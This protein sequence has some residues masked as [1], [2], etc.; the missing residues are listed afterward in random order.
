MPRACGLLAVLLAAGSALARP[1]VVIVAVDKPLHQVAA[2]W[3][4]RYLDA[5]LPLDDVVVATTADDLEGLAG[6]PGLPE[7]GSA[8]TLT[9]VLAGTTQSRGA[10]AELL[11]AGEGVPLDPLL[12]LFTASQARAVT[13]L[14][15][16]VPAARQQPLDV[17]SLPAL[18]NPPRPTS[19][20]ASRHERF[21]AT[22]TL[23]LERLLADA[24]ADG[25]VDAG[26]LGEFIRGQL[27]REQVVVSG[28]PLRALATPLFGTASPDRLEPLLLVTEPRLSDDAPVLLDAV[29][30]LTVR[31]I[32]ADDR[33]LNGV[34]VNGIPATLR[35]ATD[36]ALDGL[37]Y[38]GRTMLFEAT[39]PVAERGFTDVD[40]TAVDLA[41]NRGEA[42]F[43][44]L[45]TGTAASREAP[46][47]ALDSI[48][49]V[50]FEWGVT[51]DWRF[52]FRADLSATVHGFKGR[53][54]QAAVQFRF[55][56]GAWLKDLN[57][58]YGDAAGLVTATTDF[59]PQYDHAVVKGLRIFVPQRELHLSP[60]KK[61]PIEAVVRLYDPAAQPAKLLATS[62]PQ[63]FDVTE[64][65]ESATIYDFKIEHNVR[66]EIIRG[67]LLRTR[68]DVSGLKE[69]ACQLA[70]YL[71]RADGRPLLDRNSKFR[72]GDGSVAAFAE[73]TPPFDNADYRDWPIFLPYD[74]LDLPQPGAY[75]LRAR[76]VV[77]DRRTSRAL[78]ASPWVY[79]SVTQN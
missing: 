58:H 60:G 66:R 53:R 30:S 69:Q 37:G 28:Q 15:R 51:E 52:G 39:I 56:G 1:V 78:D 22:A 76:A 71:Q 10:A 63:P 49:Q 18:R 38:A 11:V 20:L 64:P 70:V 14:L 68:F 79:L 43:L 57:G 16:L 12:G 59:T 46:Q 6:D 19:L 34:V 35:R 29:G 73:F 77:W 21:L 31:G 32:V 54:L 55:R 45:S 33:L 67:L 26:E 24:D 50:Q 9:V 17:L 4:Q 3:G 25:Q 62:A 74:E 13:L 36:P 47:E 2:A 23:G 65:A 5:G 8:D 44:V 75:A 7:I 72:A 42:K 61:H 41:G 48:D 27:G 40:V